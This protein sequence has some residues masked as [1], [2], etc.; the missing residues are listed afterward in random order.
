MRQFMLQYP[1]VR[2]VV[3][4]QEFVPTSVSDFQFLLNTVNTVFDI[5]K[6]EAVAQNILYYNT[7][8][9]TYGFNTDPSIYNGEINYL[10]DVNILSIFQDDDHERVLNNIFLEKQNDSADGTYITTELKYVLDM[11]ALKVGSVIHPTLL[12]PI[13]KQIYSSI[14][15]SEKNIREKIIEYYHIQFPTLW[16]VYMLYAMRDVY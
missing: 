9:H 2:E 13:I 5:V 4:G 3:N 6:N 16:I 15:I 12:S 7:Q 14:P 10:N 1:Y 11:I 8:N